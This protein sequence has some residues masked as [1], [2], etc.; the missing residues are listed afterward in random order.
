MEATCFDFPLGLSFDLPLAVPPHVGDREGV[1][2]SQ[3]GSVEYRPVT[4]GPSP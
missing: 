1:L 3:R 2:W 4:S